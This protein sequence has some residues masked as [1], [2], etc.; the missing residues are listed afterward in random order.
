MKGRMRST[1]LKQEA[2][3]QMKINI[4]SFPIEETIFNLLVLQN[5]LKII[6][7]LSK[8][9]FYFTHSKTEERL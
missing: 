4:T 3:Y 2:M 6:N 1:K 9:R 5:Y 8:Y 7:K